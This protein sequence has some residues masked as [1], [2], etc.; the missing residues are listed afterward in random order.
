MCFI[1]IDNLGRKAAVGTFKS[2]D[3]DEYQYEFSALSMR[4]S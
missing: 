1:I 4:I 3:K 2:E